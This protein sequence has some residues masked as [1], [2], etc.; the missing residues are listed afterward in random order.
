MDYL[1]SQTV[2]IK[3]IGDKALTIRELSAKSQVE[4]METFNDEKRRYLAGS[5]CCKYGVPEWKEMA[6]EAIADMLSMLQ[7]DEIS[8]AVQSL[9]GLESKNS[10]STLSEDS[11]SS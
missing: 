9:S 10:D 2:V 6:V 5:V 8:K 4:F 7:I 1:K 3:S 11:S